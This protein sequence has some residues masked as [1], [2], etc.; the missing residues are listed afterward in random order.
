MAASCIITSGWTGEVTRRGSRAS[1]FHTSDGSYRAARPVEEALAEL[2]RSKDV[3]LD[4]AVVDAFLAAVEKHGW[5]VPA[6]PPVSEVV[7]STD[8]PVFDHDDL[9]A[10][11]LGPAAGGDARAAPQESR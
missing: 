9:A 4:A 5:V 10:A 1:R 8:E 2:E 3:Q 6:P 7:A 11:P